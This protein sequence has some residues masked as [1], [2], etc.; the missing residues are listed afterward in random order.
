MAAFNLTPGQVFADK[1]RVVRPLAAGG[2]GAVYVVEQLS[3]GKQR[4]LKL[5]LPTAVA[6]GERRFE[7]EARTSSLIPSEHVVDV[8]DAGVEQ[9]T[10]VPWLAMELLS[11]ESLDAYLTKRSYLPPQ[12][13]FEILEQ[14]CHALIA[15][16]EIGVV[17]RDLKPDNLFLAQSRVGAGFLVKVLDFGLAKVVDPN[18]RNTVAM[19]TPFWM[20]PEQSQADAPI[21]QAADVWALGLIAFKTLTGAYY[22]RS[23]EGAL[24][25]FYRE[26]LIDPMEP[27]SVRARAVGGVEPPPGFDDWFARAVA[28]NPEERFQH[29]RDA[30]LELAP[31]LKPNAVGSKDSEAFKGLP[32][33]IVEHNVVPAGTLVGAAPAHTLA[34]GKSEPAAPAAAQV[35]TLLGT[36][37]STA[38]SAPPARSSRAGLI[39]AAAAALVGV[40]VGGYF[41]LGKS[42]P[43]ASA[44]QA[45]SVSPA[46]AEPAAPPPVA[47]APSVAVQ[48]P[49]PA[50]PAAPELTSTGAEA[51]TELPKSGASGK[52]KSKGAASSAPATPTPNPPSAAPA[53]KPQGKTLPDLL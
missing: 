52:T 8:I 38:E 12:E 48:P 19:G 51:S 39:G 45:T 6:D 26:L 10:G 21:S 37:T 47:A 4:A 43:E 41:V 28:R 14:L 27:A 18:S 1:Y 35:S 25:Q 34:S 49:P 22:W 5:M 15:A 36:A 33:S 2:M 20:A 11:G 7:Q 40:A 32:L 44:E 16:H 3:T 23:I 46:V 24:Q 31:V 53:A 30:W 13:A 17:H 9:G 50:A 42:G 29:A